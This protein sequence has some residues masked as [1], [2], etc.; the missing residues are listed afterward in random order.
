[1]RKNRRTRG[2]VSRLVVIL[3]VMIGVLLVLIAIPLWNAFRFDSE[4]I[5]CEQAMKTAGD[6]LIIEYLSRFKESSVREAQAAIDEIMPGREENI[7]PAG[8]T[9]YLVMQDNGIYKTVCGLHDR[10]EQERT[11]LNANHALDLLT[12]A[13]RKELRFV[14]EEPEEITITINGKPL[15]CVYVTEEEP[16]RRG[17]GTTTGYEGVVA[18]YGVAG[19]GDFPVDGTVAGKIAYFLYADENYCAVWRANDGWTGNAYG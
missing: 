2:G 12:E 9:V 17:T 15:P 8:G 13:R 14:E 11:R 5:G 10:D 4:R 3:L 18:Y 6:G 1:M 19:E 16:I 7:C